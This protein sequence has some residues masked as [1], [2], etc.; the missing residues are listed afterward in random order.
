MGVLPLQFKNGESRESLS[1]TGHEVFDLAG[2]SDDLAP[3]QDIEMR[4]TDPTTGNARSIT[5]MSRIDTAV[6]V[7]YYRN[8]G[9]LPTVLRKLAAT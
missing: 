8:R 5:L 4:L 1:I 9:I 7:E 3:R 6:E 2:L